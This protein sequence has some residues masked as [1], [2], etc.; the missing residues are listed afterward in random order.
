RQVWRPPPPPDLDGGAFEEPPPPP[1]PPEGRATPSPG[2]PEVPKK[3]MDEHVR[4]RMQW[5]GLA[6]KSV[7]SPTA[8]PEQVQLEL[9]A[10]PCKHHQSPPRPSP[11]S[12][13]GPPLAQASPAA[14]A[15]GGSPS[16]PAAKA[17]PALDP[18]VAAAWGLPLSLAAQ[19]A[20]SL[21]SPKRSRSR[22][23]NGKKKAKKTKE[24]GKRL[25]M[26]HS[27]E[28]ASSDQ[29]REAKKSHRHLKKSKKKNKHVKDRLPHNASKHKKKQKA[30][31]KKE[32]DSDDATQIA[33]EDMP[34]VPAGK[35]SNFHNAAADA[36]PIH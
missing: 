32:E 19:S 20:Q 8:T 27:N 21:R 12:S 26:G 5:M 9:D 29:E 3:L 15:P 11:T 28:E 7:E 10:A 36:K 18:K 30:K 31:P 17:I 13:Q 35:A 24:S 6:G 14:Q 16:P 22:P 34:D 2:L 33:E 4:A 25:K 23:Q 1:V